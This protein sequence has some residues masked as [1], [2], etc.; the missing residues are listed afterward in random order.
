MYTAHY[1]LPALFVYFISVY[2]VITAC[3]SSC[4][5]VNSTP[6]SLFYCTKSDSAMTTKTY[7]LCLVAGVFTLA[8][9]VAAR[10]QLWQSGGL[11]GKYF[12]K[13]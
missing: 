11:R 1:L 6:I 2:I 3:L 12:C 4:T 9:F 13:L 7:L 5:G 10:L 8:E